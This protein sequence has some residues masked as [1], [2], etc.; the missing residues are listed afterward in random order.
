MGRCI[1]QALAF[2]SLQ[3]ARQVVDQ[4]I[5]AEDALVAAKNVVGRRD[6]GKV[7]LQP[8]VLGAERVGDGHGLGGDEDVEAGGKV[9]QNLLRIGH[10]GQIFEEVLGIEEGSDLLLAILRRNL[11]KA[12]AGKVVGGQR[13][14]KFFVVAAQVLVERVRH[15]FVHVHT[16][17]P[18]CRCF[19]AGSF[20]LRVARSPRRFQGMAARSPALAAQRRASGSIRSVAG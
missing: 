11:P 10:Q 17:A 12:F 9:L 3:V 8:A 7:A 13:L 2:E 5:G 15:H 20:A 14:V 19:L 6:E 1:E 4:V 18:Q 16:N